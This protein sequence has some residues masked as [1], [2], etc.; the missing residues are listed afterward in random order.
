MKYISTVKDNQPQKNTFP[1]SAMGSRDPEFN[2][3]TYSECKWNLASIYPTST[4][5]QKHNKENLVS[6]LDFK[7]FWVSHCHTRTFYPVM[8][9]TCDS[10]LLLSAD[11][12]FLVVL[13]VRLHFRPQANN[14]TVPLCLSG[15]IVQFHL[16]WPQSGELTAIFTSQVQYAC[17]TIFPWCI[18]FTLSWC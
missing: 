1:I 8:P 11:Y 7:W 4:K 17:V 13:V 12:N 6:W 15:M 10:R 2:F 16:C 3:Q 9:V 5:M 14:F 18:V